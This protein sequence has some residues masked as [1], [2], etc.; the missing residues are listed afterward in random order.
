MIEHNDTT[1]N[2]FKNMTVEERFVSL[3]YLCQMLLPTNTEIPRLI[4]ELSA[5][6]QNEDQLLSIKNARHNKIH[7]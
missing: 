3:S 2:V 4:I 1:F 7:V 5:F 6:I